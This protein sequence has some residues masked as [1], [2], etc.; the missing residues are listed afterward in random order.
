MPDLFLLTEAQMARLAPLLPD[1][2]RGVP[3]V[4]DRRIISGMCMCC[5]REA[6]GRFVRRAAKGVWERGLSR[7][8]RRRCSMMKAHCCVAGEKGE[9]HRR[10]ASAAADPERRWENWIAKLR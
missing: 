6:V 9:R 7:A 8:C 2:T 4:D 10:S 1:D 5:G 3:R